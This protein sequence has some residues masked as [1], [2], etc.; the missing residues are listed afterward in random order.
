MTKKD[1]MTYIPVNLVACGKGDFCILPK[2]TTDLYYEIGSLNYQRS[3]ERWFNDGKT[4]HGMWNLEL[5]IDGHYIN[6]DGFTQAEC[7]AKAIQS[8]RTYMTILTIG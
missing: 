4:V 5:T 1:L 6:E 2:G 7:I 8:Y 3:S